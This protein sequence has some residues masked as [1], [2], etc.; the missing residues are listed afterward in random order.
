MFIYNIVL[1]KTCHDN[2][3]VNA[4]PIWHLYIYTCYV[5]CVPI[6]ADPSSSAASPKQFLQKLILVRIKNVI[7]K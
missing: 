5:Q 2:L 4:A 1:I 3:E 7:L 6:R